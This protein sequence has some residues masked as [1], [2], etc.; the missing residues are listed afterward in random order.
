M[1]N[2][3]SR[4]HLFDGKEHPQSPTQNLSWCHPIF[5]LGTRPPPA[6]GV[7]TIPSLLMRWKLGVPRA[8]HCWKVGYDQLCVFVLGRGR[9]RL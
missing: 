8:A 2:L 3:I 5:C 6:A 4:T 9:K 1:K 7:L